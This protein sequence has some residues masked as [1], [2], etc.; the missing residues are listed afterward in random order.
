MVNYAT[1]LKDV[2]LLKVEMPLKWLPWGDRGSNLWSMQP[3]P[4]KSKQ[5]LRME[6]QTKTETRI[7]SEQ[8]PSISLILLS[9]TC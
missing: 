7:A 6:V 4:C 1:H 5:N 2:K 8:E 3:Y 9:M